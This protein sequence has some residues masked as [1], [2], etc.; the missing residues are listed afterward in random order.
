MAAFYQRVYANDMIAG[1]IK[2]QLLQSYGLPAK[3]GQIFAQG[4][5][6]S[7]PLPTLTVEEAKELL[8][9]HL[10]IVAELSPEIHTASMGQVFK[11]NINNQ[12]CAVKILHPGIKE[13]TRKE[14]E[15]ALTL[16]MLYSKTKGFQFNKNLFQRF[17]TEVFEEE[18]ELLREGQFQNSFR[19]KFPHVIIPEV[20]KASEHI[21]LQEYVEATLA[22]D[23]EKIPDFAAIEFFFEA[24]LR[25]GLLHGDMNDRNWGY[26]NGKLV[27]YDFGCSQI[28]SDRRRNGLIKLLLNQDLENAFREFGIRLEA[29]SFKGK[30]Q[31]LRDSLFRPPYRMDKSLREFCDPWILLLLRSFYSLQKIYQSRG[32]EIPLEKVLAPFLVLKERIPHSEIKVLVL[33]NQKEV[34]SLTLPISELPNLEHLIPERVLEKIR[35]QGLTIKKQEGIILDLNLFDRSYKVW[36]E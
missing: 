16:G 35:A 25:H 36:T 33:E 23:L 13:K 14:I 4:S 31:E 15:H 12:V 26:Q 28:V 34:V 19:T 6:T 2:S 7:A 27:V 10:K 30:E 21:L 20:L 22:C 9:K 5:A 1:F 8:K 11:A 32:H 17:L 3:L 24:L 18:T 29:T